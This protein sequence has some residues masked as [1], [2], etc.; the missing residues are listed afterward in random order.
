MLAL[1]DYSAALAPTLLILGLAFAVLPL[2]DP[3]SQVVRAGLMGMTIVFAW[4]Y[5]AWRISETIPPIGFDV[6]AIFGWLF[7][8]LE[9]G[10]LLSST[11][12]FFILSRSK[13][14]SPEADR[15]T[16]W[17]R[18]GPPPTV[19]I[20]I[21][22]YNEEQGILE[23]T[24]V[25]ALAVK[26][27]RTRIWVLDDGR[28]EWLRDLCERLGVHHLTRPDN[29]HAKAGNINAAFAV[30]RGL[31]QPPDF[32]AVLDAD[33]VPHRDFLD[34]T[35]A[36]FKD[37]TVGLVQ[38]PQH[39][40][41]ADPI[42]HNLG[43]SRS[44]PDE[45]RFFFD[46]L[47]PSR[48]AWGI[49]FCC[50]T[51]SV[52]RWSA[53]EAIGGF[54]VGSV[55][56]DYLITLRLR[57]EGFST[58]YLAEPLTEGLAPEGLGEYITQRGRWCLGLMQIMRGPMGPFARNR[59]RLRDRLG[60]IDSFLFWAMTY[61]FRLACLLTPL[62]YWFFGITVVNAP[63][64]GVLGYFI[65][66]LACVLIA[67]NWISSGMIVPILNDVSQLLG[68]KEISKAA[69]IGIVKPKGH[70]FKVTTK[71]GDRSRI[72]VQWPLLQ[73]LLVIFLLT[74]VGLFF[75]PATD[76]VFDRDA[77]DGKWVILF[78]TFYNLV[79][80]SAAMAVCVE[81][82]RARIATGLPPERVA[83]LSHEKTAG[84][85]LMRLTPEDAWVRGGPYLRPTERCT[86]EITGVG[87]VAGK[88]TRTEAGGFAVALDVNDALRQAIL[89]KLHT[90]EGA[91]GVLN[92]NVVGMF[93]GLTMR[94]TRRPGSGTA[95]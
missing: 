64:A 73:P 83:V 40:F 57:E 91:A 43:L 76:I 16:A 48:D 24:I 66:Y 84:A 41:N 58:S 90:R 71:G 72:V 33:F 46:Q 88:V 21:A 87:P 85:W 35:L 77:G 93:A 13:N 39:F 52:M 9:A 92:T 32:V 11:F 30:L 5:M 12:A 55:T 89:T 27:P 42:Q 65:P 37:P 68:A 25:G 36:L 63:V 19:D 70:K 3:R 79:V 81:L 80:L 54:P 50:G 2:L 49:A 17:W 10:T 15:Q 6:D 75:S 61:P 8:M 53:L 82:P 38:T 69:A 34:R 78:W 94:V 45:Q 18:P 4:R 67:L 74:I 23:R 62:L 51:S 86:L 28:R 14:R 7:A 31:D 22:T 56:E 95:A 60:L 47:Q 29:A 1:S 44:Y 59:L 26:H 20:L